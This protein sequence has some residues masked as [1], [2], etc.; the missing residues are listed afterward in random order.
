MATDHVRA[1][2]LTRER[3]AGGRPPRVLFVMSHSLSQVMV[4]GGNCPADSMMSYVGAI[5]ATGGRFDGYKPLTSEAAI[6]AVPDLIWVTQQGLQT[7]G[8]L[9]GLL[10]LPGLADTPAGRNRRVVALD[11]LLLLGMGPRLPLAVTQLADASTTALIHAGHAALL[12]QK[13]MV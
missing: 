1:T 12:V 9:E 8:G 7:A 4:A 3:L 5:N 2:R 6:A 10:R 11:A 13:A